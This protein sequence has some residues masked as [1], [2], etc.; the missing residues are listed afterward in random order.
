MSLPLQEFLQ[1]IW[2]MPTFGASR[3]TWAPDPPKLAAI[4]LLYS[5]SP[6]ITTQPKSWYS[7]H[8]PTED[9]RLSWPL[10]LVTYWDGLPAHPDTN[11]VRHK[12]NFVDRTQYATK[13]NLCHSYSQIFFVQFYFWMK[14]LDYRSRKLFCNAWNATNSFSAV[15]LPQTL[16]RYLTVLRKPLRRWDPG[17]R[18]CLTNE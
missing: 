1:F 17:C 10:W 13:I 18:L 3:L 12:S 11:W 4:I 2:Q 5:P 6:F 14:I 9:R 7:F 16:L 8:D 15:I